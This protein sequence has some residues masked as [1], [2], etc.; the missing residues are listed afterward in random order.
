MKSLYKVKTNG[1]GHKPPTPSS[2]TRGQQVS[3][4]TQ[5]L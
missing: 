5:C 4:L 3:L 1:V 2:L